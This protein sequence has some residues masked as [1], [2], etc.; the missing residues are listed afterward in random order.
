MLQEFCAP[1]S[2]NYHLEIL[3]YTLHTL[4][5]K[6]LA[7]SKNISCCTYYRIILFGGWSDILFI[8]KLD[9]TQQKIFP[10]Q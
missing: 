6:I 1:P 5:Y 7:H 2:K 9:S 4:I 10:A 3:L 8:T